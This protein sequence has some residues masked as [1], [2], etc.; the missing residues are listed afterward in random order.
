ML[1]EKSETVTTWFKAITDKKE[2]SFIS[3]DIVDFYPS[4]SENLLNEAINWARSHTTIPDDEISTITAAWKSLLF[5]QGKPWVKR[6][7]EN[8]FDVTMGSNDGAEVCELIGL[9]ILDK[10]SK[11]FVAGNVGLYR[12]DGLILVRNSTGRLAERK[13]K[14]LIKLM[15]N[16]NLK[17]TA[18]A[19]LKIVNFLDL[20]LNLND[21]TFHPYKKPNDEVLYINSHSNHPPAIIK[22]LPKSISKRIS[23]LSSNRNVF[24]YAA[25]TYN[26]ALHCSNFHTTIQYEPL[27]TNTS[28]TKTSSAKYN[29]V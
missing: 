28:T 29:M 23:N 3:F 24:D 5:H 18:T 14:D 4:I 2:H 12:D 25:P 13:K 15:Q 6:G 9:Y 17:V 20:T 1:M 11:E 19:N 26:N 21:G 7:N 8:M 27:S 22:Q 16:M 10:A